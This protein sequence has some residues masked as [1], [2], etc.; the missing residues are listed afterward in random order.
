M[1]CKI[2]SAL[3][4]LALTLALLGGCA[5]TEVRDYSGSQTAAPTAAAETAAPAETGARDY[6]E[7]YAAHAG[8]ELVV[9]INGLPV[10]WDECFY[11][12][13]YGASLLEY[14]VGPVEN[15]D[16]VCELDETVTNRQF[17]SDYALESLI[18]YRALETGAG[19]IGAELSEE[20]R[21]ELDALWEQDV[22]DY[23]GGDEAAFEELPEELQRYLE[24]SISFCKDH[25]EALFKAGFIA[26]AEYD[27]YR[28][29]LQGES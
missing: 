10:T 22:A 2:I 19:D 14:Y 15:W 29:Q 6:A 21:A 7:A 11:W 20:D 18:Q 4:C 28:E 1:K 3:T 8:D 9:T 24:A 25:D 12:L 16:A 23:A 27:K 17:I 13:S 5:S 26:H